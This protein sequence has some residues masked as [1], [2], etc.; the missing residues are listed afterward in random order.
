LVIT[1]KGV[2]VPDLPRSF[3]ELIT[4]SDK[5]VLV[6][7]WAAWCVP[8]RMVSPIVEQIAKAYTGRLITVKVNVD[9]KQ[10]IAA[11]YQISNIPTI[12]LFWKG[13]T[14]MQ[15]MGVQSF[16]Q[17]KQQIDDHWPAIQ[18]EKRRT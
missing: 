9:E 17:I 8:C 3:D 10:H 7:F 5:P 13:Q 15:I 6:D 2:V 4:T 18:S 11:Q 14:L 1:P 16:E 12:L